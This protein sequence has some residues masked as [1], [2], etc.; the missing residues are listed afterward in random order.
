M[1]LFQ[2]AK[3][4]WLVIGCGKCLWAVSARKRST[5]KGMEMHLLC[6]GFRRGGQNV[7]TDIEWLTPVTTSRWTDVVNM[8]VLKWEQED[9][10]LEDDVSYF[11]DWLAGA[12]VH[13]DEFDTWLTHWRSV[14]VGMP[15]ITVEAGK[16]SAGVDKGSAGFDKGSAV[17]DKVFDR[18]RP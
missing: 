2:D 9:D 1:K 5:V 16:G 18:G 8:A 13:K 4:A 11:R 14:L 3:S 12:L 15:A 7:V 6:P 10:P 17:I